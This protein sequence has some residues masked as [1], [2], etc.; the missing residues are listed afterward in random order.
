MSNGVL[1]G[2]HH[3]VLNNPQFVD[4]VEINQMNQMTNSA[5]ISGEKGAG[6]AS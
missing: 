4:H 1:Q 2:A 6:E 3:F 5:G